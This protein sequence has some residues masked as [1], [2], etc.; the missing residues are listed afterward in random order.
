MRTRRN[1]PG[2]MVNFPSVMNDFFKDES[3]SEFVNE[4]NKPAVNIMEDND[5]YYLD[6]IVPGFAKQDFKIEVKEGNLEV[7]AEV[8]K[9]D[10]EDKEN[11]TRRE[12]RCW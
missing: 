11:F 7:S 2:L 1:I 3:F 9:E 4:F 5:G 10:K 6:L 12:F 8:K